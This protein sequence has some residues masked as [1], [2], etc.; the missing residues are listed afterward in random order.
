MMALELSGNVELYLSVTGVFFFWQAVIVMTRP[1][2]TTWHPR[3]VVY[4]VVFCW[5]LGLKPYVY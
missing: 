1:G 4:H 2:K 5:F 3:K